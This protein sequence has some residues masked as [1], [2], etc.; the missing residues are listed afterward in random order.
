MWQF[1]NLSP[2][3]IPR[4]LLSWAQEHKSK[5]RYRNIKLMVFTNGFVTLK[6]DSLLYDNSF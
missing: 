3:S 1:I 2:Y 4:L 5:M 6:C